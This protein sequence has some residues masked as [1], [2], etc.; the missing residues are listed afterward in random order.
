M[1]GRL[2]RLE[3]LWQVDARAVSEASWSIQWAIQY[4]M[5]DHDTAAWAARIRADHALDDAALQRALII[6][7]VRCGIPRGE[8]V[9]VAA[10]GL[11]AVLM[12]AAEAPE[13]A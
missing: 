3:T 4:P 11:E 8:A 6:A 10:L 1:E 7:L 9:R 2:G 13:V 5:L 12:C